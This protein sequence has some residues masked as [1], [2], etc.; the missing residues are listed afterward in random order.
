MTSSRVKHALKEIIR[1]VEV[2]SYQYHDPITDFLKEL[3]SEFDF[4]ATQLELATAVQ[5]A[6]N[7]LSSTR[8]L[9]AV[10]VFLPPNEAC[11]IIAFSDK[12]VQYVPAY[13][14]RADD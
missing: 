2:S 7:D 8:Y 14:A 9:D 4:E 13:E 1:I 11:H 3:F 6:E 10:T 5:V 12:H